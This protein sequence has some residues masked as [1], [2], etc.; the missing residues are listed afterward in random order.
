MFI[1]RAILTSL[2]VKSPNRPQRTY[3]ASTYETKQQSLETDLD[4]RF[5]EGNGAQ[6]RL[7]HVFF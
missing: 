1:L 5:R 3:F 6:N 2:D 7:K 4:R